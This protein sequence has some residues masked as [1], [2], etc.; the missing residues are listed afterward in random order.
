MFGPGVSSI[1]RQVNMKT[2]SVLGATMLS[3]GISCGWPDA[4]AYSALDAACVKRE[5]KRLYAEPRSARGSVKC[6]LNLKG[7]DWFDVCLGPKADMSLR[8]ARVLPHCESTVIFPQY[9]ENSES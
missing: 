7:I 2:R 8:A 4:Q 5:K 6:P 9:P 1:T 3:S